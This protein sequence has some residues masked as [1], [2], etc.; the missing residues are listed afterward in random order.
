[1]CVALAAAPAARA[2]DRPNVI[3][4]GAG[5]FFYTNH[6]DDLTSLDGAFN[7]EFTAEREIVP[8]LALRAGIGYFHDG[9]EGDDLRGYPV[10]L[11]AIGSYPRGRARYFAGSRG[12]GL[13]D[14]LRRD[15]RGHV[16][17]RAGTKLGGHLLFGASRDVGPSGFVAV[18]AKYLLLGELPLN[19]LRLDLGGF[20]LTT[21]V[22]FRY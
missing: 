4:A 6:A 1:M 21:F 18:E 11:T 2:D 3:A 9:H 5:Y 15:D 14:A 20:T 22:G 19:L 16:R 13:P 17:R 7:G 12:R 10:T 8:G